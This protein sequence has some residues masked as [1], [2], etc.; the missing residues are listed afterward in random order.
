MLVKIGE[1][2]Y[3]RPDKILMLLVEDGDAKVFVEG[4]P[5]TKNL[6]INPTD[7]RTLEQTV[8]DTAEWIN[9]L[10]DEEEEEDARG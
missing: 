8:E 9:G 3:V 1:N 5:Y 10:E 6:T 7:G 2:C 4:Y